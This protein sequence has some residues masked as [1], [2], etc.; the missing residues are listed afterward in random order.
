M[1]NLL[2]TKFALFFEV[3]LSNILRYYAFKMKKR[4]FFKAKIILNILAK[5]KK[6]CLNIKIITIN[7]HKS[8]FAAKLSIYIYF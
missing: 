4:D 6:L 7:R 8:Y 2:K 3:I 1:K 5:L